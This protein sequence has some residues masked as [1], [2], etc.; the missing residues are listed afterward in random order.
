LPQ[1]TGFGERSSKKSIFKHRLADLSVQRL[2][3]DGQL[4][5]YIAAATT[6]N[7][8]RP[9]LKLALP[10]GDLVRMDV[11]MAQPAEPASSR[12]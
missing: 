12:P 4:H 7:I 1:Q 11:E 6:E 3:I 2:H 8:N 10:L 9:F 5:C